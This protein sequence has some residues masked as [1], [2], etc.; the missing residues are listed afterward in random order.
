MLCKHTLSE[1]A[2]ITFSHFIVRETEALRVTYQDR[3]ARY[4]GDRA[5]GPENLTLELGLLT[6]LLS[7]VRYLSERKV[8]FLTNL[9]I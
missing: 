6:S 8:L 5:S 4:M 1:V 2:T 9:T 3:I 7:E